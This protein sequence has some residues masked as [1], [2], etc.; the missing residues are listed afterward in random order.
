MQFQSKHQRDSGWLSAV[1]KKL[2][3]T[4]QKAPWRESTHLGAASLLP[5]LFLTTWKVDMMAGAPATMLD[6]WGYLEAG[7]IWWRAERQKELSHWDIILA[8]YGP[9]PDFFYKRDKLIFKFKSLSFWVFHYMQDIEWSYYYPI[10]SIHHREVQEG[11]IVQEPARK[12]ENC[13]LSLCW[14]I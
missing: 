4:S 6:P 3:G 2:Y 9:P 13:K 10:I 12:G 11:K 1:N 7:N 8:L 5:F 14:L